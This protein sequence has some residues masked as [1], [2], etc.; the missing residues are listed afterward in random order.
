MSNIKD[1]MTQSHRDCDEIFAQ[2]EDAVAAK[3][4]EAVVKFEEF[5]DALTNHFKMEEMVL[6]PAFEEAS[7]MREGPTQ[8]MVMEHEQMRELLSKM[9]RAIEDKDKFFG[10]SETLMI[11]MQQHNMKEEQMLY[12][13]IQE[14]L[15]DDADHIISRMRT[16]AY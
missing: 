14:R 11:L 10:L 13:M 9:S 7:G 2:M 1:F 16:V 12:T 15:E 3:S 5:A 6:F 4:D 8:V